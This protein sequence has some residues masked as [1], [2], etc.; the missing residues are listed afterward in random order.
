MSNNTNKTGMFFFENLFDDK[1]KFAKK[2]KVK[3]SSSK[4]ETY[5]KKRLEIIR[6]NKNYR[7]PINIKNSKKTKFNWIFNSRWNKTPENTSS[8]TKNNGSPVFRPGR[9]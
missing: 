1:E 7:S 8:I 6:N 9:N 3:K 2:S 5:M 4:R